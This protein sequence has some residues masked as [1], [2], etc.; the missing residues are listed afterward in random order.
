MDIDI[1]EDDLRGSETAALLQVH[2]DFSSAQSPPESCHAL[3][4]EA[5][6]APDITFWTAW[7][8]EVLLAAGA[9]K[10]L[11][12]RHGEIKSMHTLAEARGQGVARHLL[13]HIIGEAVRRGYHRLSLETGS[14]RAFAPARALYLR[15]GF[16]PCPP[17]ADYRDDANSVFMTRALQPAPGR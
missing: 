8:D 7:R 5:L 15:H 13:D 4:L 1:R 3:D 12:P 11:D 10:E 16:R 9:L 6:Q 2:L 14:M 17:F